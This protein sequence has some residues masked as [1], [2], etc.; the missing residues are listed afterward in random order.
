VPLL[1]W[2]TTRDQ[3]ARTLM[4]YHWET[5]LN[6]TPPEAVTEILRE[7]GSKTID[8]WS[9]LDLFHCYAGRKPVLGDRANDEQGFA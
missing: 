7:C 1:A 2:L 6:Y 4:R 9:E 8:R 5:I 3:R